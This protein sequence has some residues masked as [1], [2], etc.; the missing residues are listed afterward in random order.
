VSSPTSIRFSPNQDLEI[1]RAAER[2]GISVSEWVR[3]AVLEVFPNG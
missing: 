2:Q 1:E 3:R